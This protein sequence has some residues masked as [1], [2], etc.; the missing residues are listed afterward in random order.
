MGTVGLA[1]WLV[2]LAWTAYLALFLVHHLRVRSRRP[3]QK[4]EHRVRRDR[5]SAAGML[6]QFLGAL[7]CLAFR[8]P[9]RAAALEAAGTALILGALALTWH[10]LGHLGRQWRLQAVV[11]D[12]HELITTGP[13]G[14]VRHPIY[15]AFLTML[16]GTALMITAGWAAVAAH[17]LAAKWIMIIIMPEAK[18][19]TFLET[20]REMGGY[21]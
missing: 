15:A 11:T 19:N 17:S 13:Y 14:I 4:P 9:V 12:D 2:G 7:V 1:N 5:R 21:F 18:M 16:A 10:A 3:S 6:L 20:L 8:G